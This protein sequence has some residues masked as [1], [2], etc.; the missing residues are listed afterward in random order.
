MLV[1][2]SR[3]IG[4]QVLSL[5]TGGAI[6]VVAELVVDPNE[7]KI[8]GFRVQGPMVDRAAN[9][10]DASSVREF[11]R[12]G[13]VIDSVE[14]LVTRDDVVKI[15]KALE[16]NFDIVGLKVVTK[17][18][19]KLGKASGYTVTDDDFM[20]QQIIVKRPALKAFMDPELTIPRKEI[21]EVNDYKIVVKD[22]EAKIRERAENEDFIPNFVNPFR[23][24]PEQ[25]YAPARSQSPD[26]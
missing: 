15:K 25:E 22:E 7:L 14:E 10:L 5:Q 16:L 6:A 13:M 11:S 4:T 2:A 1:N 17:K 24:N 20:V 9:I 3:L 18:G 8:I 12:Y 21:V 26:E 23:K 19:T